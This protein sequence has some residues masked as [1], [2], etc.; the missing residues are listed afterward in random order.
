MTSNGVIEACDV[1]VHVYVTSFLT[2][3]P[4]ATVT[5]NNKKVRLLH[6]AGLPTCF[7]YYDYTL[8]FLL[9]MRNLLWVFARVT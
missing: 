1:I 9:K 7:D 3:D 2:G 6:F 4:L 5:F 8:L